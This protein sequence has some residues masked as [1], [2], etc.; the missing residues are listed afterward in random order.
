MAKNCSADVQAV[1]IYMDQVLTSNDSSK[2]QAFKATFGLEDLTHN[3]DVASAGMRICPVM[4]VDHLTTFIVV[5]QII[6]SWQELT[7]TA[8]AGSTWFQFCDALEV[9]DGKVAGPNGWG[10][11]NAL[12]AW[13]SYYKNTYLSPSE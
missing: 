11:E 1:I 4:L 8:G 10:L 6:G 12:A 5:S 2:I 3:D 13:G 7:L 9:K